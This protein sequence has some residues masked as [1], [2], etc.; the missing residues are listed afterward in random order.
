M[1]NW[2]N[3]YIGKEHTTTYDCAELCMEVQR[4]HYKRV[5]N[6]P[7]SRVHYERGNNYNNT[8]ENYVYSLFDKVEVP[9]DGD[10]V[11]MA[12]GRMLNHVGVFVVLNGAKYVLHNLERIGTILQKVKDV[13]KYTLTVQGY[14][15]LKDESGTLKEEN[16]TECKDEEPA[17][18]I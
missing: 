6:V 2:T 14:Y 17:I 15:R 13:H 12:N 7:N 4:E 16:G 11:L 1:D 8:I 18:S 5:V 9:E 10:I 3:A